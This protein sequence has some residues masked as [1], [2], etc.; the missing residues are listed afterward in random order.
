MMRVFEQVGLKQLTSWSKADGFGYKPNHDQPEPDTK[1]YLHP[2]PGPEALQ[3]QLTALIEHFQEATG[4]VPGYILFVRKADQIAL[5][6]FMYAPPA[7]ATLVE[8]F[9]FEP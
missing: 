5:T 8:K 9:D 2:D 7:G 4:F 1:V 3:T 6:A